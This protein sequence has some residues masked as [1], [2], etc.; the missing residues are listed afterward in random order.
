MRKLEPIVILLDLDNT[1]IGNISPQ[2]QEYYLIKELNKEINKSNNKQIKF[3]NKLLQEELKKYIIRPYLDKFIK[4]IKEYKNIELFIYT[5]SSDSWAKFLIPHI[6]KALDF[7]F[8]RPLLTRKNVLNGGKKSISHIKKLVFNSIKKKYELSTINKLKYILLIDNTNNVLVEKKNL[9][10]CP[11][12]NYIHE[13]DPLRNIPKN[14]IKKYYIIIEKY[15]N[16]PHSHNLYDF[17]SIYY[18]FLK[19]KF[20]KASSINKLYINDKYWKRFSFL[21]KQNITNISFDKL[22]QILRTI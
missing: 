6:E 20:H 1:M 17:Y 22:I 11:D 15:L 3:N 14:I 9:V 19:I 2:V 21:L 4:N 18:D 7:K 12:Y 16:F 8:N 10:V 13:I 5:A